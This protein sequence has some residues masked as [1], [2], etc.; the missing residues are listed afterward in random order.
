MSD[1]RKVVTH[2]SAWI[3]RSWTAWL[4]G[5]AAV[6]A[7]SAGISRVDLPED[8]LV[9][10]VEPGSFP[11]IT[12]IV[13][14]ADLSAAADPRID[15]YFGPSAGP[16]VNLPFGSIPIPASERGIGAHTLP[17]NMAAL[18]GN[19]YPQDHDFFVA[20]F[21]PGQLVDGASDLQDTDVA[22]V[23]LRLE[24]PAP[25]DPN[26]P[27]FISQDG[28]GLH[29]RY[30]IRSP[31]TVDRLSFVI[32][33]AGTDLPAIEYDL[34]SPPNAP[35]NTGTI[36][37]G[38]TQLA[39]M[40]RDGDQLS[41]RAVNPASQFDTIDSVLTVGPQTALVRVQ[42]N[43]FRFNVV[44]DNTSARNPE[45]DLTIQAPA[46]VPA[47][48]I[49]LDLQ[50][51]RS[52]NAV[53]MN[54]SSRALG[55]GLS[56]SLNPGTYTARPIN[57]ADFLDAV[58]RDGLT[59][60]AANGDLLRLKV[61]P[62]Q[63]VGSTLDAQQIT[64]VRFDA[65][66]FD[67][68]NVPGTPATFNYNIQS[69]G[70]ID[71]VDVD[72]IVNNNVRQD[73]GTAMARIDQPGGLR[74]GANQILSIPSVQFRD[75]ILNDESDVPPSQR[76]ANGD[77][78]T[79]RAS[80]GGTPPPLGDFEP[81]P[82]DALV[83]ITVSDFQF[84]NS[85]NARFDLEIDAPAKVRPFSTSLARGN[86]AGTLVSVNPVVPVD[87]GFHNDI[88][89][90]DFRSRLNTL[91]DGQRIRNGDILF[92]V[93]TSG[94]AVTEFGAD[95]SQAASVQV[96]V[97]RFF[98][99]NDIS[100]SDTD[101]AF[102]IRILA[103][104]KINSFTTEIHRGSYAPGAPLVD[105][106][107]TSIDDDPD[108]ALLEPTAESNSGDVRT[109]S[110]NAIDFRSEL[111]N[112]QNGLRIRNGDVLFAA[113][114]LV[115]SATLPIVTASHAATVSIDVTASPFDSNAAPNT[116][117]DFSYTIDAPARIDRFNVLLF[118][119]LDE[120]WQGSDENL[121]ISA[122]G[123]AART[124]GPTNNDDHFLPG[125]HTQIAING[126]RS[127]FDALPNGNRI[128]H[129][130]RLFAIPETINPVIG[131]ADNNSG[132]RVDLVLQSIQQLADSDVG[133]DGEIDISVELN[134]DIVAPG[135]V[136][137]FD[138]IVRIA[139]QSGILGS[140]SILDAGPGTLL[141]ETVSFPR[142]LIVNQANRDCE[143]VI[144]PP[145]ANRGDVRELD[146]VVNNILGFSLDS[147][148]TSL[149]IVDGNPDASPPIGDQDGAFEFEDQLV[150][151]S[152][153]IASS[154][155]FPFR[156]EYRVFPADTSPAVIDGCPNGWETGMK[157]FDRQIGASSELSNGPHRF[158]EI[159]SSRLEAERFVDEHSGMSIA[160]QQGDILGVRVRST[161]S[162][163]PCDQPSG[164]ETDAQPIPMKVNLAPQ[165]LQIIAVSNGI[166]EEVAATYDVDSPGR[167]K[168]FKIR[169]YQV[170][171][172]QRTAISETEISG[173]DLRPGLHTVRLNTSLLPRSITT[174]P[175]IQ[176][177]KLE[178]EVDADQ[179]VRESNESDN[180]SPQT[181]LTVNVVAN[182]LVV[183]TPP[184][185]ASIDD[186]VRD[187]SNRAVASIG[188]EIAPG[189]EA[190]HVAPFVIRIHWD[191]ANSDPA[192]DPVLWSQLV[193][194]ADGL[195]PGLH[196]IRDIA[197]GEALAIYAG[198]F[199][200]GLTPRLYALVDATGVIDEG[201]A[202]NELD[203]RVDAT[204]QYLSDVRLNPLS[205]VESASGA[206]LPAVRPGQ[207]FDV[208]ISVDVLQ[209]DFNRDIDFLLEALVR[210][211]SA[212]QEFVS[213]AGF[214]PIRGSIPL[215]G[216]DDY[217][218]I[219]RIAVTAP[220]E[221]QAP[222]GDFKIRVTLDP[223]RKI[224]EY[225]E[226]N[227]MQERFS[228]FG[229]DTADQDKDGIS[230][231]DEARGFT[232][233]R[234]SQTSSDNAVQVR[235]NLFR[236]TVIVK[237]D[238]LK[239][240]TDGDGLDDL[241]EITTYALGW[242][243]DRILPGVTV[244]GRA[245]FLVVSGL[246]DQ[247]AVPIFKPVWG[248]RTDPTSKDTDGDSIDDLSD[249]APQFNPVV[250][251]LEL[252]PS[253]QALL[254]DFDQD[255]DGFLEAPDA[256]LDGVPDFTRWTEKT[257]ERV[258]SLDFSNDGTLDDGFDVGG[259]PE[260][261]F[262]DAL[263]LTD[264]ERARLAPVDD[265]ATRTFAGS[266]ASQESRAAID[267]RFGA[268][269]VGS[270]GEFVGGEPKYRSTASANRIAILEAPGQTPD[271]PGF[272]DRFSLGIPEVDP[273]LLLP[274]SFVSSDA[275]RVAPFESITRR[276]D[277]RIDDQESVEL[278]AEGAAKTIA[279]QSFPVD[280]CPGSASDEDSAAIRFNP[281]QADIDNDGI[282]DSC[283][284]DI[285]NDG[286]SNAFENVVG[287]C[288]TGLCG[289]GA[290][291]FVPLTMLGIAL[292]S[293]PHRRRR[294]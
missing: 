70:L 116:G 27:F 98:F 24:P 100:P 77:D 34:P 169:L 6:S 113:P 26:H 89:I 238:P 201:S 243:R 84:D 87:P 173:S 125:A 14:T 284:P 130:D 123:V 42:L 255:Q 293:R 292:L 37:L 272:V 231:A 239:F 88:D 256:N 79:A 35:A 217:V 111:S 28:T 283:D 246:R 2:R 96:Y 227:N 52:G 195:V 171:D 258:F 289:A 139:G 95:S 172:G 38:A 168:P 266:L 108:S 63:G 288:G 240:D 162:N 48:W 226:A 121:N 115:A 183:T 184:T 157:L 205:F 59:A 13:S 228:N 64:T 78:I 158:Q 69:V 204:I 18:L 56:G 74:P 55:H 275:G 107:R 30:A 149:D 241:S 212:S 161:Q 214:V 197:L 46:Q 186:Q 136:N 209:N 1:T 247:R 132:A 273:W 128:S 94:S 276:G 193:E 110:I 185:A 122:G 60:R 242:G 86:P 165:S 211:D 45:V 43:A 179:E 81:D 225:D 259:V 99:D 187:R 218:N 50:R 281:T 131:V 203:N 251:S 170:R 32:T 103:P 97:N 72:L 237:T 76:I 105:S 216:I 21:V 61:R 83:E 41:I 229:A 268:Y 16:G 140:R 176:S 114:D 68:T 270:F 39:G 213:A 82:F 235:P 31:G 7:A 127:V 271:I 109:I 90:P 257:L 189:L 36:V 142:S 200:P 129:G 152:Y 279:F 208:Q 163:S 159:L 8:A 146:D 153:N 4:I 222:G 274:A 40:V 92:A 236:T 291:P 154:T 47:D 138:A 66:D 93:P 150:T 133:G 287:G 73:G 262:V 215:Q 249:L 290:V 143:A 253:Q 196:E 54:M 75:E 145:G 58:N 15:F 62:G 221:S 232:I 248:V 160:L 199:A 174:L 277:G 206:S 210:K 10:N 177:D 191:N 198:Q 17:V 278:D 104:A 22:N 85:D 71:P 261:L 234:Y 286:V 181:S 11:T 91:L 264:A 33:R 25:G 106:V 207:N 120:S 119:S 250:L 260:P 223:D 29:F 254:L 202:A 3:T 252:S 194:N 134:Y 53:Q 167:V 155:G 280:N 147:R 219:R 12:Y 112:L 101:E 263:G 190:L 137:N 245:G 182:S 175:L 19:A 164:D 44:S 148:L 294:L 20:V 156:I 178:F 267:P 57:E 80:F 49:L 135:R 166:L 67:F 23:T 141:L 244:V 188:Y 5:S 117:A 65:L 180:T 124:I 118:R 144:D 230:D 126:T 265:P 220:P 151:V 285:D 269:R 224:A 51:V 282:G 233:T 192:D 102:D 9:V